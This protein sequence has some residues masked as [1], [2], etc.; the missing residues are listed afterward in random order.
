MIFIED[1]LNL[2]NLII[3]KKAVVFD[4]KLK[5]DILSFLS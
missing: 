3:L 5:E 1:V 2:E 4:N